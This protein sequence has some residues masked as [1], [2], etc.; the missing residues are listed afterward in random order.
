MSIVGLRLL[1]VAILVMLL[2]CKAKKT[3][4]PAN[5]EHRRLAGKW[6]YIRSNGGI[7]G[8]M[9]AWPESQKVWLEFSNNGNFSQWNN[10]KI[11]QDRF[12]IKRGTTVMTAEEMDIID[13]ENRLD[14]AFA[15]TGDTLVLW[16]Q[17]NDGFTFVFFRKH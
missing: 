9:A 1:T 3:E 6:H 14:Q 5:P 15:I 7:A 12:T 16:D 13:F 4:V 10:G 17:A 8:N 11:E 2:G